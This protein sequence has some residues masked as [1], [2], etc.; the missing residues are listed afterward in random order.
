VLCPGKK[1]RPGVKFYCFGRI[2]FLQR[3]AARP[4]DDTYYSQSMRNLPPQLRLKAIENANALLKEGYDEGK[5]IRIAIVKAKQ[6]AE[7]VSGAGVPA[8]H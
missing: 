2:V 1:T 5:A 3:R 8:R 4:W 7:G 6:W